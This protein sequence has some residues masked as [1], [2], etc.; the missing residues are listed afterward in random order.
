MTTLFVFPDWKLWGRKR[1]I[2][3]F[4]QQSPMDYWKTVT[5]WI[6][7]RKWDLLERHIHSVQITWQVIGWRIGSPGY[8]VCQLLKFIAALRA[9]FKPYSTHLKSHCL[10]CHFE[11]PLIVHAG[12]PHFHLL[13]DPWINIG[14]QCTWHVCG[15]KLQFAFKCSGLLRSMVRLV[16]DSFLWEDAALSL[17]ALRA[18]IHHSPVSYNSLHMAMQQLCSL[19]NLINKACQ[20]WLQR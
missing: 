17:H 6:T 10:P 3:H 15:R 12:T 4:N 13:R 5:R 19:L 7:S 16:V 8:M 1:W 2:V 11:A 9:L 18:H 14:L 20:G